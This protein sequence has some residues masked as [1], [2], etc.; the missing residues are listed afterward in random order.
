MRRQI[1]MVTGGASGIGRSIATALVR[2]GH[3]VTVADVD[4]P[5]AKKAVATLAELGAPAGGTASSVG[6]DV[7]DREAFAAAAQ[8][9]AREHGQLDVLFNNAGIGVGGLADEM[10]DALW[11]RTIDVNL[12]GVVHG[13]QAALP[14]MTAQHDG[15][16]VN[17]ASMAGL[18]TAPLMLPYTTTK[19]AVVA[20]SR[21]LRAEVAGDGI[22]VTA[23]C[24]SFIATPLLDNLNP[25][26]EQNNATSGVHEIV[27]RF[28]G[29]LGDPDELAEAVLRGVAA[30]KTLVVYPRSQWPVVVTQRVAPWLVERVTGRVIAGYRARR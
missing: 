20:L 15:H 24:P 9:V 28:Q 22:R 1:V 25:G 27:G 13:V 6:L 23:V 16:I 3:H 19:H 10:T 18:I 14:I 4:E 12:R 2:R 5:A 7:T 29:R 8:E 17:T 26:M 21:A 30:N 11:D